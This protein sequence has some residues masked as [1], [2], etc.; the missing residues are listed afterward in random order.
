MALPVVLIR[1]LFVLSLL[2]TVA[3]GNCFENIFDLG[4]A[5]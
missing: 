4:A 3:F 2:V 5:N 1:Y